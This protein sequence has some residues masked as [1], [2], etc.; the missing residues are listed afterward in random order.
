MDEPQIAEDAE[1][2]KKNHLDYFTTHFGE[3]N[4]SAA[5]VLRNMQ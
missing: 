5:A 2:D 4:P 3:L 1:V